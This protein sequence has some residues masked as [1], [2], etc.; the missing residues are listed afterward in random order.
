MLRIALVCILIFCSCGFG[1]AEA[2]AEEPLAY[3]DP[4]ISGDP[5]LLDYADWE[6]VSA[7]RTLTVLAPNGT[8]LD[9]DSRSRFDDFVVF[10]PT[11]EPDL[12]VAYSNMS[13]SE[14]NCGCSNDPGSALPPCP[15]PFIGTL[16]LLNP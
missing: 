2:R 9:E 11:G 5:D 8:E 7:A 13:C 10:S 14:D 15:E 6:E 3:G 16:L 1:P 12:R 4:G